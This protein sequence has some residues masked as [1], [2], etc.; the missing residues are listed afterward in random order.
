[1]DEIVLLSWEESERG[2]GQRPDGC[3][4]HLSAADCDSYVKN[5]WARMPDDVPHE[6]MR[7]AGEPVKALVQNSLYDKIRS[8]GIGM[9]CY[10]DDE[11]NFVKSGQLVYGT[12]RSGWVAK[13]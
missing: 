10:R 3:S 13:A 4:L 11:Q 1:M 7:P 8:S 12:V 6:Y 9:R 5:Y 2:W